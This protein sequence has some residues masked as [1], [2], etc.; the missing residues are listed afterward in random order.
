M[1]HYGSEC[2]SSPPLQFLTQNILDIPQRF[3]NNTD[4]HK[5]KE[6]ST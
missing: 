3:Q 4:T 6:L 5:A 2:Y 1:N